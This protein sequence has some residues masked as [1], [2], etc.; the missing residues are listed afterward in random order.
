MDKT[1]AELAIAR[2]RQDIVE[3]ERKYRALES[4]SDMGMVGYG[5]IGLLISLVAFGNDGVGFGFLFGIPSV[6]L[7]VGAF[8][9]SRSRQE[10]KDGISSKIFEKKK[11]I[12]QHTKTLY[13]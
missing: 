6:L 8:V 2:L 3:L 10:Q 5:A 13:A 4:E 7:L 11:E 1:S 9:S 12:E